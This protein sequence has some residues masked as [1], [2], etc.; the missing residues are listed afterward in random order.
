MSKAEDIE[1]AAAAL[2]VAEAEPADTE[3]LDASAGLDRNR[4]Y[5]T[6][7]DGSGTSKARYQQDGKFF[8]YAGTLI[9]E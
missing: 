2:A 6:V 5:G 7:M 1:T 9:K 3:W 8:D 4:P